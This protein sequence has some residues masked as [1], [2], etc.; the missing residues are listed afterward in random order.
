MEKH[1]ND[2]ICIGK[3]AFFMLMQTLAI[4][5]TIIKHQPLVGRMIEI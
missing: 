1:F 3:E 4:Q 5:D 2:R